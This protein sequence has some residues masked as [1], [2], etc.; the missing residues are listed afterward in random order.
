[1]I[2]SAAN[3]LLS[4]NRIRILPN[5]SPENLLQTMEP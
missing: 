5:M 4:L 2:A 3:G 1:G